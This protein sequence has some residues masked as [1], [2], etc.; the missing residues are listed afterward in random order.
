M[1]TSPRM[2][3]AFGEEITSYGGM[4]YHQPELVG[5][6]AKLYSQFWSHGVLDQPTKEVVRLRNARTIDC[7]Y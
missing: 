4:L 3:S 6:Y 2:P 1:S 7:G 5:I